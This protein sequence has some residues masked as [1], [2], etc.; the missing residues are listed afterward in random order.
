[1]KPIATEPAAQKRRVNDMMREGLH[2]Q[3]PNEPIPFFCECDSK[4][5]YEAV[6]RTGPQYDEARRDASWRALAHQARE[7]IEPEEQRD[8]LV[9]VHDPEGFQPPAS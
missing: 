3:G 4:A 1:M 7:A 6:W 5:C 2:A 9:G 8:A